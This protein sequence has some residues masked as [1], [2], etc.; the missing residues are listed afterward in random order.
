MKYTLLILFIFLFSCSKNKKIET[1]NKSNE[2]VKEIDHIKY[3]IKDTVS[4]IVIRHDECTECLDA[5]FE[6]GKLYMSEN[7]FNEIKKQKELSV[8][9]KFG[10]FPQG[11]DLYLVGK[12]NLVENLFGKTLSP[13]MDTKYL[14]KG[15]VI[16]IKGHGFV[17]QV[18][19]YQTVNNKQK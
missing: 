16:K 5:F 9:N 14:V 11:Y 13:K 3:H 4:K 2:I 6:S 10:S 19:S 17:F 1:K 7:I 8:K 18:Y 12:D 15:K